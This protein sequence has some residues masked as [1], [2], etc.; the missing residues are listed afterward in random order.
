MSYMT[1]LG[2]PA[3]AR[4]SYNAYKFVAVDHITGKYYS[5]TPEEYSALSFLDNEINYTNG[6]IEILPRPLITPPEPFAKLSFAAVLDDEMVGELRS[7]SMEFSN[8]SESSPV[9]EPSI[10]VLMA[11]ML[12]TV[13]ARLKRARVF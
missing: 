4:Y 12:L 11:L 10:I 3:P 7:V 13:A 2:N 6:Q 8:A 1:A 9:P 5:A